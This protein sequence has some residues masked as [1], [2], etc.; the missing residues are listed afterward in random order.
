MKTSAWKRTANYA[1]IA[2]DVLRLQTSNNDHNRDRLRR[3][4]ATRM[5]EMH[6]LPQKLGQMLSFSHDAH[7]ESNPYASLQQDSQPMPWETMRAV[8][9][10]EWNRNLDEVLSEFSLNG[11]AA[12]LGQVHRGTLLDGSDVAIKIQYPQIAESVGVDLNLLGWA[13]KPVAS[14]SG[15]DVSSYH[16]TMGQGISLELDYRSEAKHQEQAVDIAS[17]QPGVIVPAVFPKLT[18][19]R[20]L[21]TEW[22]EGD[23]WDV[24]TKQWSAKHR[25]QVADVLLRFFMQ[26]LFVDGLMQADWHPGN[27]RFRRKVHDCEM[28]LYDFGC[29]C[30]LTRAERLALVRLVR[31]TIA[32]HES[33]WPLFLAL[34]FNPEYLE[35]LAKKLPAICRILFEPF[36]KDHRYDISSWRLRDRMANVLGEDRWNFR[37]AGP[38]RLIFL[39]RAFHGLTYYLRG[40]DAK[41]NW[42]E[43]FEACTESILGDATIQPNA[44]V[45]AACDFST[46]AKHLCVRL[47]R[48]GETRVNISMPAFRVDSLH[49]ILDCDVKHR[50]HQKGIDLDALMVTVRRN[51]YSPGELFQLDE[52]RQRLRVWLE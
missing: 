43:L 51:G 2:R 52:E 36:C 29:V 48:G 33:P 31:A 30:R 35:P 34:G 46:L 21:V 37:I 42:R 32:G 7:Q 41:S 10:S 40:L 9:E 19:K 25:Q 49:E 1:G 12:S 17:R 5:G 23:H 13:G 14:F 6:G 27:T 3:H 47:E 18:T 11:I 4:L 8:A 26:G 16:E 15:F 44:P 28:V 38:P 24:V 20:V 22:Q 39:M 50:I 45:H